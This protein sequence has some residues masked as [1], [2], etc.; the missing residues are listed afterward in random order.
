MSAFSTKTSGY[1]PEIQGIRTIGALLVASFHIW[2]GRV[3]G[4]VDVF[5]VISGFLITG[6]LYREVQRNQTID[7]FAFWG[8][9]AKRIAP[10]AYTVMAITLL[11]AL[12]WLPQ[13]RQQ[14]FLTE[15]IYSVLHLENLKLMM[16]AVDYLAR[17]EAPSPV[18]QFWALSV[19][20]QFYAVWPFLLLGVTL[21]V[22]RLGGGAYT[23]A[24]AFAAVF[25]G[26]LAYSV[27][28]TRLDPSPT[29]FNTSARVW[30]FALGGVLAI[31]VP[32][33]QLPERLREIVG[34][35]GLA[36]VVSCGFA[37]PASAHYPGYIALW[38]TLGAA[39][40]ILSG[41]GTTRFGADRI[42]AAKPLVAMGD[43]SF[44][45][46]LWH[47]PVLVFALIVTGQKQLGLWDGLAVIAI[48]LCGA[49]MTARG[50]EQPIQR[51]AL[52]KRK[53]WH[54]HALATCFAI[55]IVV[56]AAVWILLLETKADPD[57]LPIANYPGGTLPASVE[58]MIKPGIPLMPEFANVKRDLARGLLKECH[59]RVDEAAV[60]ECE[61]GNLGAPTKTIAVV[62]GSHSSHWLPP[63]EILAK[64][65]GWR[66][67]NIT[68]SACPFTVG[69]KL[70]P[71]C[72]EWNKNVI[73]NLARL[74]PDVVFTPS[75]RRQYIQ[76]R[77]EE[78]IPEGY[79]A[80]WNRL[81]EIGVEVIAVRDNPWLGFHV[82]ECLEANYPNI[83]ACSR[84]RNRVLS[85]TDP[86]RLLSARPSNVKFID[87]TDRFCDQ[88]TCFPVS[89]NIMIYGDKHHFTVTFSRSMSTILGERMKQVRPDLFPSESDGQKQEQQSAD[90]GE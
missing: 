50:L 8:R 34:W 18:Q 48:A 88:K 21:A 37:V 47:W 22:R 81:A 89:G 72:I 29:Y 73:A 76:G 67:V 44:S 2:G 82:P 30:E 74:K 14:G 31:L 65:Y 43:I 59:Q 19:Q 55:P 62:G 40:V 56:T 9:I 15:V 10:M 60:I 35:V 46:Y 39:L 83:M 32:Y 77:K 12:L 66:V 1:R 71:T 20:V 38:P 16:N 85:D 79:Q 6:S 4:G 42:L 52:G 26:S 17:D 57:N 23:Y 7:V 70:D 28:Q 13:S 33:I 78:Y 63:L 80:Q 54:I 45:F 5:F 69:G 87:M 41:G 64:K 84:P 51:S 58:T 49:Y 75:T 24:A 53:V 36:A 68:K 3:S 27:V 90:V 86:S 11:A 61:F 25:L